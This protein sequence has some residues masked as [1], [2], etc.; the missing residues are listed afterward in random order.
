MFSK[1]IYF[2]TYGN[3]IFIYKYRVY[4]FMI[5]IYPMSYIQSYKYIIQFNSVHLRHT[6][7]ASAVTLCKYLLMNDLNC[8]YVSVGMCTISEQLIIIIVTLDW[9]LLQPLLFLLNSMD[10]AVDCG[11]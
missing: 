3:T 10:H 2:D 11:R 6:P 4:T 7:H 9:L 8:D 1:Y 5:Q